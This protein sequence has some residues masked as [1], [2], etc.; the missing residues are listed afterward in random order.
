MCETGEKEGEAQILTLR[1]VFCSFG[2]V[3]IPTLRELLF[4]FHND[5]NLYL[6][7]HFSSRKCEI[8]RNRRN[9]YLTRGFPALLHFDHRG[10]VKILTLRERFRRASS[11]F[12]MP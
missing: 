3:K 9:P 7:R 5:Q 8:C 1:E 6:T 12:K 4:V 11:M 2:M 10:V